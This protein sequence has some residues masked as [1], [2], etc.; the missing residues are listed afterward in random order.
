M[1]KD[2]TTIHSPDPGKGQFLAYEAE[3]GLGWMARLAPV[4][5]ELLRGE[6]RS[7][8]TSREQ[9]ALSTRIEK[10]HGRPH[11]AQGTDSTHGESRDLE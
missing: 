7:L 3:D 1:S 6:I 2:L 10:I 8:F 5:D 9:E 11:T 4:W